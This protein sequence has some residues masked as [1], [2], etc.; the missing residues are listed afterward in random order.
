MTDTKKQ[1]EVPQFEISKDGLS[2]LIE[3][4]KTLAK[5][6]LLSMLFK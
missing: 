5:L 6:I 4:V 3:F 2:K 1:S